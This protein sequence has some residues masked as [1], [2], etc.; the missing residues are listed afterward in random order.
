V[1]SVD[2]TFPLKSYERGSLQAAVFTGDQMKTDSITDDDLS[3]AARLRRLA[4]NT[5]S[6]SGDAL[7]PRQFKVLLLQCAYIVPM[8]TRAD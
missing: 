2:E 1:E 8:I 4:M 7:H 3:D 6:S 5:F